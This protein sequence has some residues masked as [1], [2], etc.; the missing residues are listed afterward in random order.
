VL[1]ALP[2]FASDTP[3]AAYAIA[4]APRERSGND[5]VWLVGQAQKEDMPQGKV[6]AQK[7]NQRLMVF[8]GKTAPEPREG[9]CQIGLFANP[10][11]QN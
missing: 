4:V 7:G 8:D 3:P 9:L 5:S 2:R 1:A 6:L 10:L 11:E